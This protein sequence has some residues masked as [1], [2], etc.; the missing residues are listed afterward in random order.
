MA[1]G[2][3]TRFYNAKGYIRRAHRLSVTAL[4]TSEEAVRP[5]N[6]VT[7]NNRKKGPGPAFAC[8]NRQIDT[9]I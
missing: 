9:H 7:E 4:S 5:P 2:N 3:A 1:P 6:P 8:D